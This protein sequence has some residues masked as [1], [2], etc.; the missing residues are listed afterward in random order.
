VARASPQPVA[1][2]GAAMLALGLGLI[3]TWEHATDLAMLAT[4]LLLHGAGAGLFQVAY[5]EHVTATMPRADRGVAGS[6]ANVTRTMGVVTGASLLMFLF[7]GVQAGGP[8]EEAGFLAGF[9]TTFGAAAMLC[10]A[11][12]LLAAWL[13]RR[14]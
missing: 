6:L 3:A 14:R 4:S 9:T 11:V 13:G 7:R 12:V 2:A 1:L 10:L 8:D 5:L